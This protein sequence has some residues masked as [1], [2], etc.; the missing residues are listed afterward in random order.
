MD[1]TYHHIGGILQRRDDFPT[2]A[3]PDRH[4]CR[5]RKQPV[6][7]GYQ[8]QARVNDNPAVLDSTIQERPRTPSDSAPRISMR[9]LS[10][11]LI[12]ALPWPNS[13]PN[14]LYRGYLG[15]SRR[16]PSISLM[17]STSVSGSTGLS[18]KTSTGRY[19]SSGAKR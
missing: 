9:M 19:S 1:V 18:M 11:S 17:V 4:L 5:V 7:L 2:H 10:Y 16:S 14:A 3:F 12:R 13:L 8:R 15:F 6:A